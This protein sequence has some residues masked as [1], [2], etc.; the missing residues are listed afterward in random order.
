[1][2]GVTPGKDAAYPVGGPGSD[3]WEIR[4]SRSFFPSGT[5]SISLVSHQCCGAPPDAEN[6]LVAD[7]RAGAFGVHFVDIE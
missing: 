6:S 2:N 7:R 4:G 3:L 5:R 1:M